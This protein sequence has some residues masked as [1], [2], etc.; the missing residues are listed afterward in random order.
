MRPV[1]GKMFEQKIEFFTA[2]LAED[3]HNVITEVF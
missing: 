1:F 2:N 3:E